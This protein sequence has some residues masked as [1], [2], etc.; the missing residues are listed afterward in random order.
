MRL[1]NAIIFLAL[2]LLTTAW[3]CRA[4]PVSLAITLIGDVVDDQDIHERKPLLVGKRLHAADRMFGERHDTLTQ[5]DGDLQWVIYPEPGEKF[6]ESFFVV[7]AHRGR[8][9]GLF[10]CKRNLDGLEDVQKTRTL[11]KGL[12]GKTPEQCEQNADLHSVVLI[13]RSEVSGATVRIYD[14]HNWTHL[15]GARYCVLVFGPQNLCR[16]VRMLGVTATT[17]NDASPN[18]NS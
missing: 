10:K 18:Q 4:H 17:D 7:E 12:F 11:E 15:K 2:G 5:I 8:I 1:W 13:A 14:A 16:E 3:G 9:T 6:A